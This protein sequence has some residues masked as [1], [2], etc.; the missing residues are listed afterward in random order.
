VIFG[1]I[2]YL[3]NLRNSHPVISKYFFQNKMAFLIIGILLVLQCGIIYLPF[4]NDIFHTTPV[5][6]VD[7]WL[8]PAL[9]G[10]IVLVVTEIVKFSHLALTRNVARKSQ[11]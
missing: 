11:L 8:I 6:I 4:M 1:K 5:G 3:F 9:A 10:L 7:G 2:F